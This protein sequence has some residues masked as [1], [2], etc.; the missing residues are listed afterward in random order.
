[1]SDFIDFDPDGDEVVKREVI[2]RHK[3]PTDRSM[4]RRIALQALYE[5][6]ATAHKLGDVLNYHMTSGREPPH[7]L[8]YAQHLIKGVLAHVTRIDSLLQSY[9][10]EW[11]IDQL[12]IVDRNILRIALYELGIDSQVPVSA[13]IDE[14]VELAHLFGADNSGKFING[15]LGAVATNLDTVRASLADV[16]D[17]EPT[18]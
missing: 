14:A 18:Q 15:V 12:A 16:D 10:P 8:D 3:P 17:V 13:A 1:M 6:D 5:V 9:A 11:P 2:E 4:S 7:V